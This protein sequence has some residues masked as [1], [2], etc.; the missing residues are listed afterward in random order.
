MDGHSGRRKIFLFGDFRLDAESKTIRDG[1]QRE[2][3]LAKRPFEVLLYLIENRGRVVGRDELLEKFWDGHDVY[4]DALRKCVGAIRKSLRDTAKPPRL[5]ETRYGGGYRF[6]GAV[7]EET[8]EKRENEE[9]EPDGF[10]NRRL[11]SEISENL[12]P[13][14]KARNFRYVFT[15][16]AALFFVSL[17]FFVYYSSVGEDSSRQNLASAAA[18][19][20]SSSSAPVR[21]IAVLPLK[22]LTGD[23]KN[24]YLSD[25]ITESLINE[26]SQLKELKVTSRGSAF[27]FKNQELD[28][29]EIGQK[30][31][32]EAILEGGVRRSGD[33]LRVEVRL[34]GTGDGAVLWASDFE[35]KPLADIFKI[36]DGI[37]CRLVSE[38]KVKICGEL[39]TAERYT[40]NVRAYQLY[41]QGLYHRNRLGGE[42]LKRAVEFYEEALRAEPDY[43]LAHEG[44]ATAYM[45][46]EFNS[47]V[48]PGS[49]AAKAL[50][51]AERALRSDENLA[52]AYIVLGAVK[53]LR[54]YDLSEREKYYQQALLKYPNHRTARLWLSNVYTARGEF[55]KA[56]AEIPSACG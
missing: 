30:L 23:A 25:G 38:L 52:G 2:I 4:A 7:S 50:F 56:E 33:R 1:E 54:N 3:H 9:K 53:T 5:I 19:A 31:G 55:E 41:L 51:H 22:N 24:D 28:A 13:N 47:Q 37:V 12:K 45:L 27:S 34:V 44:L 18:A 40:K 29:R 39:A 14:A 16:A 10:E 11:K 15:A 43:A 21:S 48:A 8:S 32:V 35:E 20:A 42:D 49:V 17:G 6:V 46:M 26:L 36:Q